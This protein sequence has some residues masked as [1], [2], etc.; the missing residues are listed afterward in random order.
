MRK[1]EKTTIIDAIVNLLK[2]Y[3]N[4]YLTSIATLNAEK[5][6]EL[7][8]ECA[9]KDVKLMMVK[10]TLLAKALEQVEG[11]FSELLPALKGNTALM[12]SQTANVP[13][14]IIAGHKKAGIPAFKAAYVQECI[15]VGAESLSFLE[16]I[17]SKEEM[18]GEVV[19]LL[20]SPIK[21]VVSALQSGGNTIHG[22]LET[23]QNR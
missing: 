17:K 3:P 1:E 18:L 12:C 20:Q 7:R 11:D 4:F 19:S 8:K 6:T 5:T 9:Q 13:A 16:N 15:Y 21:N 2:E 23:L 10:N 22:V 14:K